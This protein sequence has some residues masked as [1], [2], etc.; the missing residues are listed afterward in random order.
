MRMCAYDKISG[1]GKFY[2][3]QMKF[4]LIVPSTF[5][6]M[7]IVGFVLISQTVSF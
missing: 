6:A 4:V 3:M 2:A 1:S 5:L 7:L